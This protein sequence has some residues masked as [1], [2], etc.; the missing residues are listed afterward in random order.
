MFELFDNIVEEIG[1]KNAQ[2]LTNGV[3]N[4]WRSHIISRFCE[5]ELSLKLLLNMVSKSLVTRFD[6]SIVSPKN[7]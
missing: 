7:I 6:G 3:G 5:D 1:D 4:C 2:D